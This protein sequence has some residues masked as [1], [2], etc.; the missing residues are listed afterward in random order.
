MLAMQYTIQLAHGYDM[1]RIRQRALERSRLFESLPGLAHKSYLMNEADEIYAPFYV[2]EDIKE[3]RQFMLNDL[4][5]GVIESF[6]RPRI[7]SWTILKRAYGNQS[8]IPRFAVRESDVIPPEEKLERMVERESAYQEKLLANDNLHFHLVALDPDR[9]EL[10]RYSLWRDERSAIPHT[11]DVVQHYE[12]LHV[13]SPSL[14]KNA[15][16][17]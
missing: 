10:M 11:A 2:W 4:F 14:F 8:I 9:W 15:V 5:G 13:S 12:V 16:G 3:A 17:E 6:S 1:N 7:R